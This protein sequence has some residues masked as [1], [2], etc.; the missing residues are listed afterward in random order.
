LKNAAQK[1]VE[2]WHIIITQNVSAAL[3]ILEILMQLEPYFL[4]ETKSE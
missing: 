4:G 2:S 3:G 1:E